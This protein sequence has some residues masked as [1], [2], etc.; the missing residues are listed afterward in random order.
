MS[1]VETKPYLV[2]VIGASGGVGRLAVAACIE[3]GL[4]TKA[5]VRDKQ[6]AAALFPPS[7]V[8][9]TADIVNPNYG[10]G[11]KDALSGAD[12]IVIATGS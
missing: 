3:L 10:A 7:V 8:S 2:A 1:S 4:Q 12:A 6:K 5:I 9:V 11:L